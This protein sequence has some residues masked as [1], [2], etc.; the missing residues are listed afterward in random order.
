MRPQEV[1]PQ[2]KTT[3]MT[4]KLMQISIKKFWSE[5]TEA[6]K[7]TDPV[8]RNERDTGGKRKAFDPK[9]V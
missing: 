5:T 3:V 8:R 6:D 1:A 2:V 4:T 7:V 9:Q